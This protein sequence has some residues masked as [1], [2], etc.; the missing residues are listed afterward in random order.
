VDVLYTCLPLFHTNALNTFSQAA[1]HGATFALGPRFSA[2]RFWHRTAEA[3]ATRTYLL[4]AMVGILLRQP[5]SPHDRAHRV[6]VALAPATPAH[7]HEPFR[8]RFGV[9]LVD[10][11]G[12]TETNFVLATDLDDPRPGT[13]GRPLPEFDV[14]V[15]G[16][17]ELLV[18]AR[19]PHL[20]ACGYLGAET[21][22]GWF[23]TGDRVAVDDDGVF[24]FVDRKKETIRRRG[25]NVSAWEVEQTLLAHP[26]VAAAAVVG[27]PS[28]LGEEE[29]LAVVVGDV[30]P[31]A[32]VEHCSERL[33]RYAVPRFV[34]IVAELP[35]APNGKVEKHKLKARGVTAATW[36][37]ERR[38]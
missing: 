23:A 21:F 17:G 4:G 20:T 38:A 10:G 13:L 7:F 9:R 24:R 19:E 33:P 34:E 8:E 26:A 5:P 16:D 14:R 1:L 31:P 29:V 18:H 27:V 35:L 36:D 37:R 12:S 32:L 28:E 11:W 6:Q 2:S 25:E 15:A 30:D 22:K 3:A